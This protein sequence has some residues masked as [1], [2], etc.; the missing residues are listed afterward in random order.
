MWSPAICRRTHS[1]SCLDGKDIVLPVSLTDRWSP[2]RLLCIKKTEYHLLDALL[3]RGHSLNRIV[4][5]CRTIEEYDQT[6]WPIDKLLSLAYHLFGLAEKSFQDCLAKSAEIES[7]IA[8]F[9]LNA[10]SHAITLDAK[11]C[12]KSLCG[13]HRQARE[14]MDHSSCSSSDGS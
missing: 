2:L 10:F 3:V 6:E 1:C 12:A 11:N 8:S 4:V 7:N 13:P 5:P 9:F 14:T